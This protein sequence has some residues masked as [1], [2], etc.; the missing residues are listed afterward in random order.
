VPLDLE[1]AGWRSGSN[2]S[3][4]RRFVAIWSRQDEFTIWNTATGRRQAVL[5]QF[6]SVLRWCGFAPGDREF[7]LFFGKDREEPIA[8]R[9]NL[10]SGAKQILPAEDVFFTRPTPWGE[11]IGSLPG[12][13]EPLFWFEPRSRPERESPSEKG[14]PRRLSRTRMLTSSPDGRTLARVSVE[15]DRQIQLLDGERLTLVGT[16]LVEHKERIEG[17]VFSP[18]GKTLASSSHDG[19][20]KLWDVTTH[21]ELLTLGE[22]VGPVGLFGGFAPDGRTLAGGTSGPDGTASVVLWHTA[23][24]NEAETAGSDR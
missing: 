8:W 12:A 6:P 22:G 3:H 20:V 7:V 4:D 5:D 17:L 15:S 19:Q 13:S 21:E 14:E 18:D 16:K 23:E 11:R 2:F 9:C 24:D 1:W 10:I